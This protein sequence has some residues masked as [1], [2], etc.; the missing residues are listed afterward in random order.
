MYGR[1]VRSTFRSANPATQARTVYA[2]SAT[3]VAPRSL[4][5]VG[6]ACGAGLVLASLWSQESEAQEQ[7][8]P[9]NR[10]IDHTLLKADATPADV[11]KLCAGKPLSLF[12]NLFQRPSSMT[13]LPFVSMACMRS[14]PLTP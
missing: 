7:N 10:Y 12:S 9:L 13:L 6:V 2:R 4:M 1:F 5:A 3:R 14:W 8:V 11:K